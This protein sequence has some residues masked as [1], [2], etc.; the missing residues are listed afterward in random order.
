M[1]GAPFSITKALMP[2][3]AGWAAGSVFANNRNVFPCR[4]LVIHIFEPLTRYTRAI[5]RCRG[6]DVLQI[7][8]GIGF[9][10]ANPAALFP[11][12]HPGQEPSLLLLGAEPRHHIAHHR[13]TPDHARQGRASRARSPRRSSR[14]WWCPRPRRRTLPGM[15][16]PNSPIS[17]ICATSA[18]GYSSRCSIA[19]ATGITSLSTNCRTVSQNQLLLFVECFHACSPADLLSRRTRQCGS[20]LRFRRRYNRL[21]AGWRGRVRPCKAAVPAESAELS[22][23]PIGKRGQHDGLFAGQVDLQRTDPAPPPADRCSTCPGL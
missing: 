11:G 4:A 10:Q 16:S 15:F 7:R 23:R 19:E 21:R 14:T 18:C 1:P 13:V 17:F 20:I 2:R 8:A 22:E 6:G 5:A 3:C 9:G 12:R